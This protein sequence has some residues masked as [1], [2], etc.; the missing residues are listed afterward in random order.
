MLAA[1]PV[2]AWLREEHARASH[3]LAAARPAGWTPASSRDPGWAVIGA[4]HRALAAYEKKYRR[5]HIDLAY[6]PC[7][8]A[9]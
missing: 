5:Q 3:S 9:R 6:E 2:Q 8:T 7:E 1:E 4:F